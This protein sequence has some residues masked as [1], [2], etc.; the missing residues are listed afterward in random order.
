MNCPK[1]NK[2][3]VYYLDIA[4]VNRDKACFECVKAKKAD[5]ASMNVE[6]GTEI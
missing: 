2:W 4:L 3:L 6:H 1:C 5:K